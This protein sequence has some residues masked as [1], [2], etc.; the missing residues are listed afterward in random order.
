MRV[1]YANSMKK[2]SEAQKISG[3][4]VD[5]LINT[6]HRMLGL[7]A[8]VERNLIGFGQSEYPTMKR[9]FENVFPGTALP[10]YVINTALMAL[11]HYKNRQVPDYAQIQL[12]VAEDRK[13]SNE[14]RDMPSP[15]VQMDMDSKIVKYVSP[16][17]YGKFAFFIPN[18]RAKTKIKETLEYAM[19][20]KINQGDKRFLPGNNGYLPLYK[21]WSINADTAHTYDIL[22]EFIP[23]IAPIL[24]KAGY[25][26]DEMFKFL[27]DLQSKNI[28]V[29]TKK[30]K[31][32]EAVLN[33]NQVE[34]SFTEIPNEDIRT[35]MK[36]F[37]M[38]FDGI[39]KKW[40]LRKPD[41]A[42]LASVSES[43]SKDLFDVSS[44]ENLIS[45][46][47]SQ[48]P[49]QPAQPQQPQQQPLPQ[50]QDNKIRFEVRDITAE[51]NNRWHIGVKFLRKGMSGGENL[52]DA[53]KFS[54]C[55]WGKWEEQGA[56]HRTMNPDTYETYIAGD[57][58]EYI[59]FERSLKKRGFDTS[60]LINI[61]RN[62]IQ[63]GVV[64]Q[65]IG[66]GKIDGYENKDAIIS[67]IKQYKLTQPDG[68][69]FE[70][71]P[72][73]IESI[74]KMYSS[75]S[76]LKGDEVGSGKTVQSI[77]AADLRMKQSGGRC[78]VITKM[79]PKAQ[80]IDSIKRFIPSDIKNVSD[81]PSEKKKWTIMYYDQFSSQSTREELTNA[82][83]QQVN[84]GDIKV[85]VLDECHSVKNESKRTGNL[86]KITENCPFVW[87]MSATVIAN[88]L[89]DAYNQ[90]KAVNHPLSRMSWGK[91]AVTFGGMV[92]GRYGLEMDENMDN[93]FRSADK[94]KEYLIDQGAY[95]A[96]YKDQLREDMPKQNTY[97]EK[98]DLD[99]KQLY[100]D[101]AKRL[102]EFENPQPVTALL[103]FREQ[104][105]IYKAPHTAQKAIGVLSRG[106]K[107]MIFTSFSASKNILMKELQNY[108]NA[109]GGTVGEISG[110]ITGK[111]R[112][113]MIQAFKD[114]KSNMKAIVIMIKAGGT[115]LD[116]PNI[117]NSVFV[118]DFEW[119]VADDEQMGGRN[120]RISSEEDVSLNYMIVGNSEDEENYDK[121]DKKKSI[122]AVIHQLSRKQEEAMADGKRQG[123]AG[124]EEIQKK[125]HD[126]EK[127]M[128]NLENDVNVT[129]TIHQQG[130]ELMNKI[131]RLVKNVEL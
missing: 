17:S 10:G 128:I 63:R 29:D 69:P 11:S 32:V 3:P 95:D 129:K 99:L 15:D 100:T 7:G 19:Q 56:A 27:T 53:M 1:I 119:S 79:A 70:L 62:L 2:I 92:R 124:L 113:A 25:N 98:I 115:G 67:D 44:L 65:F 50:S 90:L 22:P 4:G 118:N 61:I 96:L 114:K 42:A 104:A 101:V 12:A 9:M 108:L 45:Q 34:I 66:A 85:I 127:Q 55:E 30:A 73:Q 16:S 123:D 117:A 91:F 24:N 38:G 21:I 5:Y 52:K 131:K 111:K 33:N 83:T 39:K 102:A 106:E 37:R 43:A 23:L 40:I 77:I 116:F 97:Q 48:Q 81:E 80:W 60:G 57:Y 93:V 94:L 112:E 51:T 130:I 86:Q 78:L 120:Y 121:L 36:S 59:Y 46:L 58:R 6:V 84:S 103:M 47:K 35:V 107:V 14:G 76:M 18:L 109:S 8:P 75:A 87:G 82:L 72:E 41:V 64:K 49:Q 105:A 125:L 71:F 68:K 126:A 31:K 110:K 54:F 26:T 20:E 28:Q 13:K 89:V 122:A 74:T 88:K